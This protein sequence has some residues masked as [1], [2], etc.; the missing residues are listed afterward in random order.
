[1]QENN[2]SID[3]GKSIDNN[4]KELYRKNLILSCDTECFHDYWS[5]IFKRIGHDLN[6][7]FSNYKQIRYNPKTQVYIFECWNDN[8]CKEFSKFYKKFILD[9]KATMYFYNSTGYD[10]PMI[11]ICRNL[12]ENN[13]IN[14][15]RKLRQANDYIIRNKVNYGLF[16]KK[17]WDNFFKDD[18]QRLDE[19]ELFDLFPNPVYKKFYNDFKK[20]LANKSTKVKGKRVAVIADIQ[21]IAGFSP[22]QKKKS[23]EEGT[24]LSLKQLQLVHLGYNQKFDFNRYSTIN[25]VITDGH[26][27]TFISYS[28]ND[29]TSLE[30]MYYKYVEQHIKDRYLMIKAIRESE[31]KDINYESKLIFTNKEAHTELITEV[32]GLEDGQK[33]FEIDYTDHIKTDIP[34]FNNFVEFVNDNQHI[35]KDWELK[36]KYRELTGQEV[37]IFQLNGVKVKSGFGGGHGAIPKYINNKGNLFDFDYTSQY[38]CT[39]MQYAEYFK[40]IIDVELY[41]KVYELRAKHKKLSKDKSLNENERN[42]YQ[43]SQLGLKLILNS[44]S[45]LINSDFKI[46][47]ASKKLGRF[48]V[49]KCQSL[50]YNLCRANND[51][52]AP[53]LNTDGVYFE[54]E[55]ENRI[56]QIIEEDYKRNGEGY[57]KLEVD[58]IEKIVQKDVNDY[59]AKLAGE[60]TLKIKGGEYN[61]G[62]KK[63]FNTNSKIDINIK[64]GIKLLFGG[65]IE[66]QPVYFKGMKNIDCDKAH[67]LTTKQKGINPVN[68]NKK[69]V[70][71][72]VDNH[73]IYVTEN[74]EDADLEVYKFFAEITKNKIEKFDTKIQTYKHYD[75]ILTADTDENNKTLTKNVTR[76]KK[77]L[78]IKADSIGYSGFMGTAKKATF[79]ND[80]PINPLINYKKSEIINSVESQGIIV[81]AKNQLVIIDI[82]IFDKETE[83]HKEG[84]NTILP[85]IDKLNKIETYQTWNDKTKDFLNRKIIFRNDIN[86]ILDINDKYKKYIEIVDISV[87]WTMEG[88]DRQYFDNDIPAVNV[89]DHRDIIEELT[90]VK[91]ENAIK[92]MEKKIERENKLQD[93]I[94]QEGHSNIVIDTAIDVLSSEGIDII[95]TVYK[96]NEIT[97][98][99]FNTPCPYCSTTN[100]QDYNSKYLGIVN[101]YINLNKSKDGYYLHFHNLSKSC[102]DDKN[103]KEYYKELNKKFK[104]ALPDKEHLKRLE[105]FNDIC[106]NINKKK[107]KELDE[108]LLLP[109]VCRIV[110]T[111]GH[112]TFQSARKLI[113]NIFVKKIFHIHSTK[114]NKHISDFEREVKKILSMVLINRTEIIDRFLDNE[115]QGFKELNIHK[116]MISRGI[117]KK[118]LHNLKGVVTNHTYWYRNGHSSEPNRN[119]AKIIDFIKDKPP[120]KI[121]TVIDEYESFKKK[122]VIDIDLNGYEY[123]KM[124]KDNE[125]TLKDAPSCLFPATQ[126]IV[127]EHKLSPFLFANEHNKIE[128]IEHEGVWKYRIDRTGNKNL[129]NFIDKYTRQT[130]QTITDSG[131]RQPKC[132]ADKTYEHAYI[133]VDKVKQYDIRD[134]PEDDLKNYD[135]LKLIKGAKR[136][137]IVRKII[138]VGEIPKP[139]KNQE[140]EEKIKIDVNNWGVEI[141]N[142][143]ELKEYGYQ[144]KKHNISFEGYK[145]QLKKEVGEELFI[146]TLLIY[147]TATLEKIPGIKYYLT[148]NVPRNITIPIN[149]ELAHKSSDCLRNIDVCIIKRE[150]NSDEKILDNLKLSKDRDFKTLAFTAL[151]TNI[152]KLINSEVKTNYIRIR[153]TIVEL[154]NGKTKTISYNT[155][156]AEHIYDSIKQTVTLSYINGTESQGRNYSQTE[157]LW[158]NCKVQVNI[159]SRVDI[160][161]NNN[162]VVISI[163]EEARNR[164]K[165]TIGRIFRGEQKYKSII[166]FGEEDIIKDVFNSYPDNFTINFNLETYNKKLDTDKGT[167]EALSDIINY[168]EYK[169]G[170]SEEEVP[171]FN[172]DKRKIIDKTKYDDKEIYNYYSNKKTEHY[173]KHKKK[174]K[175]IEVF[176]EIQ[177]KFGISNTHFR[178]IKR[179][180]K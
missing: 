75:H 135:F 63:T 73:N 156:E 152:N 15:L 176:Q 87:V 170:Y 18:R 71:L 162:I 104:E 122:G 128:M 2:K 61:L 164:L 169:L 144:L 120:E 177:E 70:K 133:T 95:E 98:L 32:L 124:D 34:E 179:K 22:A 155:D 148:A 47:I 5:F 166:C 153:G 146:D 12:A 154:K 1:M 36:V 48:I 41:K 26:Y 94:I 23:N 84:Y 50:L 117:D 115:N 173:K 150:K 51:L 56:N 103:H 123:S 6:Q 172:I 68:N 16:A 57:Y 106:E 143:E 121:E 46:P 92:Y 178:R 58:V 37:P 82:D 60:K 114:E 76:I 52:I 97:I 91:H 140:A 29:V 107:L 99:T 80:N 113:E 83:T 17:H 141:E 118:A 110:G 33:Y 159:K 90:I 21:A 167:Q 138:K 102:K 180:F 54:I 27:D 129:N 67:Y 145:N 81:Q 139:D 174:L 119:M 28:E 45:G 8:D 78:N 24:S 14:I 13:Q 66:I 101:A 137:A 53:N 3:K 4:F 31:L 151:S 112:K 125:E 134:I 168:Y 40:N 105:L 30:Y 72:A 7:P 59:I 43:Q 86:K 96:N 142:L 126:K 49:L 109:N 44:V 42:R 55:D 38:P 116:L 88:L 127:K 131:R 25:Q 74:K 157:L 93:S 136:L 160:D 20:C 175:D 77:L 10:E 89:S 35:E 158:L 147:T 163:E 11:N 19:K 79:Y 39:I 108:N 69:P 62:I 64:N 100:R 85:M 111:G 65:E 171:H 9:N 149:T 161:K 165:Q 130:G 132:I